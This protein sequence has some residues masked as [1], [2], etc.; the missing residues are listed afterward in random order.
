VHLNSNEPLDSNDE[1]WKM[2]AATW[3]MTSENFVGKGLRFVLDPFLPADHFLTLMEE[4]V[5]G[6]NKATRRAKE[7]KN[8]HV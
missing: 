2:K 8:S 4:K 3:I 5:S 6:N 1:D 7:P